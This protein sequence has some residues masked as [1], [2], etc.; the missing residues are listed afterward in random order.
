MN[1]GFG[2]GHLLQQEVSKPKNTWTTLSRLGRYFKPYAL[3]LV[4]VTA[5]ILGNT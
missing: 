5:L 3:I 4:L 1:R 2:P